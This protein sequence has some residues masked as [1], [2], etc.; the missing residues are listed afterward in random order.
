MQCQ[1]SM[2]ALLGALG[3]DAQT[4]RADGGSRMIPLGRGQPEMNFKGG[5]GIGQAKWKYAFHEEGLALPKAKC[6][7]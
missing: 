3:E 2:D 6:K 1:R 5:A 4:V 7:K